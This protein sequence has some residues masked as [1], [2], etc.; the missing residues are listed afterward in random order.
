MDSSVALGMVSGGSPVVGT[1]NILLSIMPGSKDALKPWDSTLVSRGQCP[2][3][4]SA[5]LDQQEWT[6]YQI[7]I[8]EALQDCQSLGSRLEP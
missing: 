1:M 4:S 7:C 6:P 3:C 8:L 5:K 2:I